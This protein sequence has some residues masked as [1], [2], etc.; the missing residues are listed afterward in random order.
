MG[1]GAGGPGSR[2]MAE[3]ASLLAD[4]NIWVELHVSEG[5]SDRPRRRLGWGCSLACCSGWEDLAYLISSGVSPTAHTGP[6]LVGY[7]LHQQP[8][9]FLLLVPVG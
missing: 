1:H 4:F 8:S 3:M 9:P 2:E 6:A 7:A 5:S